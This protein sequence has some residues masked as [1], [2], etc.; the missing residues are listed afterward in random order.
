V[1]PAQV[2]TD[3]TTSRTIHMSG[4]RCLIAFLL[5]TAVR[6]EPG[7]QRATVTHFGRHDAQFAL[8][9]DGEREWELVAL[10]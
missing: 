8:L 1:A 7:A 9:A 3:E 5:S 2:T 4:R 6:P 10:L